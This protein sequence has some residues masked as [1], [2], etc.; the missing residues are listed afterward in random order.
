MSFTAAADDPVHPALAHGVHHRLLEVEDEA[1]RALDL[2]LGVAGQRPVARAAQPAA[3]ARQVGVDPHQG[4][5][6]HVTEHRDPAMVAGD[7][8]E[9]VAMDQQEAPAIGGDMLDLVD[10]LDVAE[11]DA[12]VLA[13][14]LVM[15]AGHEHHPAA[16]ARPPKHLLDHGVLGRR[17]VDA[18]LHGPEIDD[19]PHQVEVVRLVVAQE[20]EQAVGLASAGT[21]MHIG[22]EDGANLK[23]ILIHAA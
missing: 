21:Q 3:Q 20:V 1:H 23:R 22:D 10:Q 5:V 12:G 18:A 2:A 15:V 19:I 11:G 7:L 16:L 6:G 14:R 4:V 8:V 13:Q 17:P 9:L